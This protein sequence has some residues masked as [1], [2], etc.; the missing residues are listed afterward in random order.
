MP[1]PATKKKLPMKTF[2]TVKL[3]HSIS[4]NESVVS[5]VANAPIA[6]AVYARQSKS[7]FEGY[8]STGFPIC[9]L[10]V[11]GT[12]TDKMSL[13]PFVWITRIWLR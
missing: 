10:I 13:S 1:I 7:D 3:R 4:E 12:G 8:Y 6:S 2:V 11:I 9:D 5:V